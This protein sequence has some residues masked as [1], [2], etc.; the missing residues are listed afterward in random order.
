MSVCSYM[1]INVRMLQKSDKMISIKVITFIFLF[2]NTANCVLI[3]PVDDETYKVLLKLCNNDFAVPVAKQK[4]VEKAAIIK[5][6]KSKGKFKN[7]MFFIM[8]R[9]R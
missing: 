3:H 7:I 5:F 8:T 2:L 6:W 9:E 1:K 4:N